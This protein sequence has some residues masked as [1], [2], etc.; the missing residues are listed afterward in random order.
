M[1]KVKVC[2]RCRKELPPRAMRCPQPDCKLPLAGQPKVYNIVDDN[3]KVITV[4][5]NIK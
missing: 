4:E 3:G 5:N 2:P 1:K